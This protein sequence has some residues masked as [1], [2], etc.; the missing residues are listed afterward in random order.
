MTTDESR[1]P[2]ALPVP[3]EAPRLAD[4]DHAAAIAA[5]K[6]QVRARDDLIA[7]IEFVRADQRAEIAL[8]RQHVEAKDKLIA[9]LNFHLLAVQRTIGW[10]IL[11]RLRRHR[12]RLL[13]PDS[14]RRNLYWQLRRP[15]EV[16]LDEGLPAVF[17][18]TRHKV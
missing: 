13:P 17:A 1:R 4:A 10:K 9:G 11:E 18:K 14:R 8:L 2:R 5:L 12:D 15:I 7:Q 3:V 6:E 16:L